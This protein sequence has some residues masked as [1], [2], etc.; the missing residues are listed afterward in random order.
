M[1]IHPDFIWL[2][3]PKCAGSKVHTLFARYFSDV[4]GL[5]M[6]PTDTDDAR[7]HDSIA[8]RGVDIAG[9][10]VVSG[11]RRLPVWLQS[12]FSYERTRS[13]H[14]IHSLELLHTAQF[15]EADGSIGHADLYCRHWLP[16]ELIERER[17]QL[18]RLED[19]P[20][21]FQR[22]FG[23]WLPVDRI[24][25]AE[26]RLAENTSA[27]AHDVAEEIARHWDG[28]YDQCPHWQAVEWRAFEVHG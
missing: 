26:L 15:R 5:V 4:P 7:W 13:P 8:Q 20:G 25:D 10:T 1:I 16:P 22:I 24:P 27:E 9:R 17:V 2:H 6:D 19:F 23:Q 3:F 11:F 18:L 14:L 12:R 21:D 28:V